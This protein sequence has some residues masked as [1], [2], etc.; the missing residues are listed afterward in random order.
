MRHITLGLVCTCVDIYLA[1]ARAR[2]FVT[3]P[4]AVAYIWACD[5]PVIPTLLKSQLTPP[6]AVGCVVPP[7]A[8]RSRRQGVRRDWSGPHEDPGGALNLG[9]IFFLL[10]Y[11]F[12]SQLG[13]Y[14]FE[15]LSAWAIFLPCS[16][17]FPAPCRST[18]PHERGLLGA[19]ICR[20]LIGC[21]NLMV[22]P[23]RRFSASISSS[24]ARPRPN[25]VARAS[26]STR[27][28]T[29][30]RPSPQCAGGW[31]GRG[32]WAGGGR[33]PWRGSGWWC[34]LDLCYFYAISS[35]VD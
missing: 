22:C 29:T 2:S 32:R 19:P 10:L 12:S 3:S 17:R 21:C 31:A 18:R 25:T 6:F 24:A 35:V 16:S 5:H 33:S 7:A 11:C 26:S 23:A 13:L 34:R 1:R 28:D 8:S 15:V 4:L 30:C 27:A 9:Y 20:M 14:F